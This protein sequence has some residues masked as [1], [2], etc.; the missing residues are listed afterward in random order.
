SSPERIYRVTRQY[1]H[2]A[3]VRVYHHVG[4]LLELRL[5]LRAVAVD[6]R[7]R[8]GRL[9]DRAVSRVHV[10]DHEIDGVSAQEHGSDPAQRPFFREVGE[11]EPLPVAAG[12]TQH[13][14]AASQNINRAFRVNRKIDG[15]ADVRA[16]LTDKVFNR[17]VRVCAARRI[18]APDLIRGGIEDVEPPTP[19]LHSNRV[20]PRIGVNLLGTAILQ[21]ARRAIYQHAV[22]IQCRDYVALTHTAAI[23]GIGDVDDVADGELVDRPLT[24]HGG[25]GFLRRAICAFDGKR[26]PIY[27][28]IAIVQHVQV[29][30]LQLAAL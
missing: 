12:I 24:T 23:F 2:D 18:V 16:S 27:Q 20:V 5:V 11:V 10:I 21:K 19:E 3:P 4:N 1:V 29:F 14:A 6:E 9:V 17:R 28:I 15:A 30:A 26:D 7:A 8:M 25:D 13:L 22:A